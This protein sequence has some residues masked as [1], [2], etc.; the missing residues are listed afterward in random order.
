MASTMAN[1]V[2]VLMV[3]PQAASTP[4]VPSSTTGTAMVGIRVA[5]KFCKNRY[6]TRNTS[7]TASIRV[8]TTSSIEMR[9]KGV[10]S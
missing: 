9:T 8:R 2:R 10:V 5:R 1:M 4:K 3:K 6:I 7:T